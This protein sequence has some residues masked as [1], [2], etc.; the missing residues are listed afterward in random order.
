MKVND[1]L[2]MA[3][4]V[5]LVCDIISEEIMRVRKAFSMGGRVIDEKN[6]KKLEGDGVI[7]KSVFSHVRSLFRA[8]VKI[9]MREACWE[10]G[11]FFPRRLV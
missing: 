1:V 4:C 7:P 6:E 11:S 8:R 9:S 10:G 3:L 5:V 2:R